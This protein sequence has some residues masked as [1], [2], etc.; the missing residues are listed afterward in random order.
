MGYS[1]ASRSDGF[2]LVRATKRDDWGGDYFITTVDVALFEESGVR[3]MRVTSE[4]IRHFNRGRNTQ[5]LGETKEARAD[6][7]TILDTCGT[8]L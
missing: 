1:V 6:V 5:V 3:K 2:G 7:Q 8:H 4:V